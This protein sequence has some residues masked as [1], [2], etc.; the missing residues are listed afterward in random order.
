MSLDFIIRNVRSSVVQRFENLAAKPS[1]IQ[2]P[3]ELSYSL[4]DDALRL[5][6]NRTTGNKLMEPYG[7]ET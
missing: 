5:E 6:W 4:D 7:T 1:I 2:S 3:Y